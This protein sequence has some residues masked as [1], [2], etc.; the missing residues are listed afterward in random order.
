MARGFEGQVAWITGG[1]SGI[2]RAL[3]LELARRGADVAVS[4]RR[5][6]KL[7]AVVAAIEALGRKGLAVPCDVGQDDQ[8][9]EAAA[10]VVA[11][12]G[13]LDVAV[14]NAGMGVSGRFEKLGDAEWR[15]QMDANLFGVVSTARW[16]LP[17]LRKTK[18]RLALVGSV[19]GIIWLPGTSAYA[20]SKFAVRAIGLTLAQELAGSGV[21]CTL[22]EPGFVSS[23][24]VKVDNQGRFHDD[25]RD[26]RPAKLLW[27]ADR[28]AR[29]MARAILCRR[30]EVVFTVHG[31]LAAFLGRHLGWLV[32]LMGS[33]IPHR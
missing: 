2:G 31:K 18:G 14:A 7:D 1:G 27:P 9:R 22:I 16:A 15:R 19:S 28:A 21:S 6:E 17:E 4:G 5:V 30:R 26:P 13:R 32:H 10:K 33:R 23:D 29:V 3:A 12:F 24:I 11:H 25:Y 8:V 20:A